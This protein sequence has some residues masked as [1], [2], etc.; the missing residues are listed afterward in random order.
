VLKKFEVFSATGQKQ[1]FITESYNLFL[2]AAI[3]E[4]PLMTLK[5]S[6]SA[7]ILDFKPNAGGSGKWTRQGRAETGPA[8]DSPARRDNAEDGGEP[9]TAITFFFRCNHKTELGRSIQ[10]FWEPKNPF[11]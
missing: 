7:D 1:L 10:S 8:A 3:A 2:V 5:H 9:Y 11:L 6:F 4:Q